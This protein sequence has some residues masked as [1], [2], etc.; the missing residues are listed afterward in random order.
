MYF[1]K[2][3]VFRGTHDH[4]RAKVQRKRF[5]TPVEDRCARSSIGN[6]VYAD[7]MNG[8]LSSGSPWKPLKGQKRA[9]SRTKVTTS[10]NS[11]THHQTNSLKC[12]LATLNHFITRHGCAPGFYQGCRIHSE[13]LKRRYKSRRWEDLFSEPLSLLYSYRSVGVA[14]PPLQRLFNFSLLLSLRDIVPLFPECP[15]PRDRDFN[16]KSRETLI[17]RWWNLRRRSRWRRF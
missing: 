15:L 11:P 17:S 1:A 10:L 6:T 9:N 2:N 13:R 5:S 12:S 4:C 16:F 3:T 14:S 7:E 8:L